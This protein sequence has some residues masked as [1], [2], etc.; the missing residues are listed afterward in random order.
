MQSLFFLILIIFWVRI[1]WKINF[2]RQNARMCYMWHMSLHYVVIVIR[3]MFVSL[4]SQ[5][6]VVLFWRFYVHVLKNFFQIHTRLQIQ[7]PHPPV[8]CPKTSTFEPKYALKWVSRHFVGYHVHF[9]T[10]HIFQKATSSYRRTSHF[11]PESY[12]FVPTYL[13]LRTRKNIYVI[14]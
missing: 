4:C 2:N 3:V 12:Q 1:N 8:Q 13:L 9:V 11:V 10:Y 14:F 7:R 6:A 5:I